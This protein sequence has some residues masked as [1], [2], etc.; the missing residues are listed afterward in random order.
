MQWF[1][2][3]PLLLDKKYLSFRWEPIPNSGNSKRPHP[4]N[5]EHFLDGPEVRP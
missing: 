1:R 2:E 5:D 4:P 3:I